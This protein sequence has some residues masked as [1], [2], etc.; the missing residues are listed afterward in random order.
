MS[1]AM[2]REVRRG[3][4][5]GAEARLAAVEREIAAI[6]QVFPELRCGRSAP[7][8][9]T[10]GVRAAI[11]GAVTRRRRP[12]LSRQARKRWAELKANQGTAAD[13]AERKT[14]SKTKV[15]G[16]ALKKK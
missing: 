9:Y 3:A 1:D 5:I 13:G 4:R 12:R 2:T 10:A 6:Y 14:A 15:S 11:K 7:N 8:P 16:G